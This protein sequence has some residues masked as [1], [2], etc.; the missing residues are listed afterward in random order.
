MWVDKDIPE[1]LGPHALWASGPPGYHDAG[2]SYRS[3]LIVTIFTA[4]NISLSTSH[5][6][7]LTPAH[8]STD[9]SHPGYRS[10]KNNDDDDDDEGFHTTKSTRSHLAPR[11]PGSATVARREIQVMGSRDDG[12][13]HAL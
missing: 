9:E 2:S 8:L 5:H 7:L 1:V 10:W 11:S 6:D 13:A 4:S 12:I 3:S